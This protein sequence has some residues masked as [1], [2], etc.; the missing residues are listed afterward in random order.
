MR[1]FFRIESLKDEIKQNLPNSEA[2]IRLSKAIKN[3]LYKPEPNE[4]QKIVFPEKIER[5]GHYT[6][7]VVKSGDQIL[8]FRTDLLRNV[9]INSLNDGVAPVSIDCTTKFPALPAVV[10]FRPFKNAEDKSNGKIMALE[11]VPEEFVSE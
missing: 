11:F 6:Y 3:L 1:L 5:V 7:F 2:K 8:R 10:S 9:R 4:Q